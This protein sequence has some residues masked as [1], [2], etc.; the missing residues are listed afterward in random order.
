MEMEKVHPE[1]HREHEYRGEK[2]KSISHA[3]E[4]LNDAAKDSS[5]DIRNMLNRDYHRLRETLL[6]LKPE[7]KSAFREMQ[8][9]SSDSINRA[10]DQITESTKQTAQK[11]EESVS[12]HPWYYIGS[13]AALCYFFGYFS[14][15]K[16]TR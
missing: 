6:D 14:G 11:M 13:I 7:L 10:K 8:E 4:V 15:R 5:S 9:A 12:K 16:K 3:L 2:V 1:S